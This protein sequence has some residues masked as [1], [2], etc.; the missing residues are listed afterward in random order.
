MRNSCIVFVYLRFRTYYIIII[1]LW[2][3][4]FHSTWLYIC[5]FRLILYFLY[6]Y[7]LIWL[8]P[9]IEFVLWG[10]E[11]LFKFWNYI[12]CFNVELPTQPDLYRVYFSENWLALAKLLINYM[13]FFVTFSFQFEFNAMFSLSISLGQSSLTPIQFIL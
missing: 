7:L 6:T 13:S 1:K 3:K 5:K 12:K 9:Y 2:R 4:I 8:S 11:I 10:L